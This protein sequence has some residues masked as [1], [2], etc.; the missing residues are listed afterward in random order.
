MDERARRIGENEALYRSVNDRIEGLNATFGPV[1][2]SMTVV[3]ECGRLECTEQITLDIPA[4]EH[5]R[6]DPTF[7]V[8]LPGHEE[9][10]VETVVEEH[11]HFNVVRKDPGG[12]AELARSLAD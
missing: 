8:L 12:P 5:V 10:D 6:S 9:P 11:G 7:F 3:C 4:Y 2:E 1:A